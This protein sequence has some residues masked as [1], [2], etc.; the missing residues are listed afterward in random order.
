M[1]PARWTL[2]A[3]AV[4]LAAGCADTSTADTVAPPASAGESADASSRTAGQYDAKPY[5]ELTEQL[6][7]AGEEAFS[8]LGRNATAAQFRAAERSFVLDN[9]DL[10][11]SLTGAAPAHLADEIETFL[12]GMRQ[13]GGLEDSGVSQRE[14]TD[15]E[16][17]ILTFEKSHC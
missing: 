7:A 8:D 9:Q 5:C 14:A 4:L 17:R 3:A 15:A 1:N 16:K 2:I 11:G 10:L 6:E 13:R 12:S